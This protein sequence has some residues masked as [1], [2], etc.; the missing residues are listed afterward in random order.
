V[1]AI[2]DYR[3]TAGELRHRLEPEKIAA[4]PLIEP[5]PRERLWLTYQ[6][7]LHEQLLFLAASE[8]E[9]SEL[10]RRTL[11]ERIG[12]LARQE[13]VQQRLETRMRQRMNDDEPALR[14]F[15]DDN[16]H[17]YQTPLR[18]KLKTLNVAAGREASRT[19]AVLEQSRSDLASGAID[20]AAAAARV[21]GTI[22]D[23][24]WIDFDTLMSYE[25]KVRY[26]VL[27]LGGTGYTV[28]F[29]LNRRLSMVWVEAR[30]EPREQS[31]ETVRERVADDFYDR[32]QQQLY[33]ATVDALLASEQFRFFE[34]NV[35]RALAPSA[36]APAANGTSAGG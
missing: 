27:E 22:E 32:H 18:L 16:R 25:P 9:M 24:G 10:Q 17:L 15:Y 6:D 7:L 4:D 21:G 12:Q 11:D 8:A 20:F 28:P 3:L 33:R 31:F 30:E 36:P 23:A 19:Q 5:D 26:Y 29:Q 14:R 13:L 1:L 34:E 2:G 35:R